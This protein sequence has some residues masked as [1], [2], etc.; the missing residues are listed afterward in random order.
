MAKQILI[1]FFGRNQGEGYTIDFLAFSDLAAAESY[2]LGWLERKCGVECVSEEERLRRTAEGDH[3][4]I[5][6]IPLE[7][8]ADLAKYRGIY[9]FEEEGS[10]ALDIDVVWDE[11]SA[12][13]FRNAAFKEY[14]LDEIFTDEADEMMGILDQVV[15]YYHG[16]EVAIAPALEKIREMVRKDGVPEF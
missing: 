14:R 2:V 9:F 6:R 3:L 12:Q 7:N 1:R 8:P 15:R 13:R 16:D 5:T 10:I 11:Q 4:V